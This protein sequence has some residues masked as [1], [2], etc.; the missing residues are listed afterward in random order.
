MCVTFTVSNNSDKKAHCV[1]KYFKETEL[2]VYNNLSE[3]STHQCFITEEENYTAYL[4]NQSCD[5]NISKH[6]TCHQVGSQRNM[7]YLFRLNTFLYK[8]CYK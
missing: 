8:N 5:K 6:S 2:L 3:I 7:F 4:H 1:R